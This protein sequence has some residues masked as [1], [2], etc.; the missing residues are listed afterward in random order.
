LFLFHLG[1]IYQVATGIVDVPSFT[2]GARSVW[3]EK[4]GWYVLLA[5][6]AVGLGSGWA[7]LFGLK[8]EVTLPLRQKIMPVAN[9]FLFVQGLGLLLAACIFAVIA[10]RS[11]GNI[12]SYSRAGL[13]AAD[14]D[15]RGLSVFMMVLPGALTLLVLSADTLVKK[16]FSYSIAGLIFCLF[17][18][19]G[20]RSAA[21]FPA[22]VGVVLWVKGGKRIPNYIAIL[23]VVT[24]MLAIAAVG[25]FR[26]MGAYDELGREQLEQSIEGSSIEAAI[27]EMGS[28]V[29]VFAQVL[30]LV[31]AEDPYIYGRSYYVAVKEMLPNVAGSLDYSISR[32]AMQNGAITNTEAIH[33]LRP[34]DWLTYKLNR[35]KFDEGQGLGFSSIAEAYI[36]FGAAGVVL[37]F[38]LL[39]YILTKIDLKDILLH[40]FLYLISAAAF[41]PLIKTVRND[42]VNLTKPFA[43]VVVVLTIWNIGLYVIGIRHQ[44]T[45]KI[46]RIVWS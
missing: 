24:I 34:A 38:F 5:L 18:L 22:L 30:R 35:W 25:V 31:P 36:N 33:K 10:V 43:F 39:G 29:G 9:Q 14:A 46:A 41:W 19:A 27:S 37:Y 17:M 13:F 20:Y 12:F 21:L 28:T 32:A 2:E 42:F 15:S 45:T 7:L 44:I 26:Q 40:P 11:Y 1:L 23:F 3:L 6:G 4:A 8:E 16:I